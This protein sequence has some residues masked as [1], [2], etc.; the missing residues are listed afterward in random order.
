[1]KEGNPLLEDE[2]LNKLQGGLPAISLTGA[3]SL[4]TAFAN[5]VDPMLVF[6]Q[7]L[8]VLGNPGD[9]LLAISTSGSATNVVAAAKMAKALGIPVVALTGGTG[10]VLKHMADISIIVP[11]FETFRVQELHL[12]VYHAICAAVE[13]HF[14][15]E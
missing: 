8:S 11:E 10:G 4:S 14:F 2:V 9:V 13:A 7:Q 1:M 6:V 5:D 3:Y 15:E 12:P